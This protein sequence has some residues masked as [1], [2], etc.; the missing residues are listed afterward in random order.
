MPHDLELSEHEAELRATF[1]SLL[2]TDAS[3]LVDEPASDPAA[4]RLAVGSTS[5][6]VAWSRSGALAPIADAILRV[7]TAR[8]ASSDIPLVAAPYLGEAGRR[9]CADEGVG[10]FDLSGNASIRAPGLRIHVEG[11]PNRFVRRGRPS[12]PFAPKASRVARWL[13]M[14]YPVALR[15]VDLAR[16]SHLSEAHTSKVVRRLNELSLVE[17]VADGLLR[18]RDPSLLLDAW[19]EDYRFDQHHVRPGTIAARSGGDALE[20]IARTFSGAPHDATASYAAS[21]LAGAWL[22]DAFASFRLVTVFVRSMPSEEASS[23][24]GFLDETRGANVWLVRP[25]D[26]G[27]FH[28]ASRKQGIMVTHPVQTYLDLSAQPERAVDA[29]EHLRHEVLARHWSRDA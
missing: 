13:L 29:A 20:R 27:V 22:H 1:A 18:A 24:M 15:Q 28:G 23:E 3:D 5:F 26:A 14:E 10:W 21:G 4:H 2:D 17:H 7:R 11:R 16:R 12:S 8:H 19:V 6:V 25:K 9:R